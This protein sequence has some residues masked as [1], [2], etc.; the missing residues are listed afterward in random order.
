[1]VKK[2]SNLYFVENILVSIPPEDANSYKIRLSS[3]LKY[4]VTK[5]LEFGIEVSDF[6]DANP[7]Q[8]IEKND[9]QIKS[10]IGFKF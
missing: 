2:F 6:Y 1:L 4:F 8:G 5:N 7:S 9:L 10:T 3:G